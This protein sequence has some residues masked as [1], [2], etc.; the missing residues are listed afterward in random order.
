MKKIGKIMFFILIFLCLGLIDVRENLYAEDKIDIS[1]IRLDSFIPTVQGKG[2]SIVRGKGLKDF[3]WICGELNDVNNNRYGNVMLVF[4]KDIEIVGYVYDK[5]S[6]ETSGDYIDLSDNPQNDGLYYLVIRGI[7]RYCGE[8][9]YPIQFYITREVGDTFWNLDFEYVVTKKE[10]LRYVAIIGCREDVEEVDIQKRIWVGNHYYRVVNISKNAFSNCKSLKK[11]EISDYITI[12]EKAFCGCK[13]LKKIEIT[14]P[15]FIDKEAFSGCNNLKSILIGEED[16]SS[17]T[18]SSEWGSKRVNISE[19]AFFGCKSLKRVTINLGTPITLGKE[20]FGKCKNLD[21]VFIQTDGVFKVGDKAFFGC[22]SLKKI[23]ISTSGTVSIGKEAFL[24]CAN[25]MDIIIDT[26]KVLSISEKAFSGCKKLENMYV[27]DNYYNKVTYKIAKNAFIKTSN[28]LKVYIPFGY[29]KEGIK[30]FENK[31]NKNLW[32][33]YENTVLDYQQT[34]KQTKLVN[35][36][37]SKIIKKIIKKDMSNKQKIKVIHDWVVNHVSYDYSM[38]NHSAYAGLISSKHKTV[39]QG[40][41]IIMKKM[42][43]EAGIPSLFV[44]GKAKGTKGGHAWNIVKIG[45]KWYHLDA[46]WDDTGDDPKYDYFLVGENTIKKNHIIDKDY[47][48]LFTM[49]KEDYKGK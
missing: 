31:G 42:L 37:V 10:G 40:Y 5:T 48:G 41:A 1:S 16:L 20:A 14:A 19:K 11:V 28:K 43:D 32:I 46:T 30:N 17:I 47:D 9:L 25:L 12:G 22:K 18:S 4:G 38:K 7:D 3:E 27:N 44:T 34:K 26:G 33:D 24:G 6:Y 2:F 39:C 36:K 29:L 15:V 35:K 13:S 23:K 45:G 8:I 21:N 49:S